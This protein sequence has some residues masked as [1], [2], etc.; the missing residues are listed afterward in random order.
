M[1]LY[2]I[3]NEFCTFFLNGAP[4]EIVAWFACCMVA[5]FGV[6]MFSLVLKPLQVL[7]RGFKK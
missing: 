7:L 3:C 6:A 4:P 5:A 2:E 1:S